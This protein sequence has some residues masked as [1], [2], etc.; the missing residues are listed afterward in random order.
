M[1]KSLTA[2]AVRVIAVLGVLAMASGVLGAATISCSDPSVATLGGLINMPNSNYS[3]CLSQDKIYSGFVTGVNGGSAIPSNWTSSITVATIGTTDIHTITF[4][5]PN[6]SSGLGAGT[7]TLDFQIAIDPASVNYAINWITSVQVSANFSDISGSPH[8]TDS[9]LL[10]NSAGG[11]IGTLTSVNGV[12]ASMGVDEKII[13]IQETITVDGTGLMHSFTDTFIET[14][15]P[16]PA[17]MA[18]MGAGLLGLGALLRRKRF[19]K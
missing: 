7:Y 14:E 1:T 16:E 2:V 6:G 10:L 13:D 11:T 3:G 4:N 19:A 8:N 12:T 18:L 5:A 15:T 17:T 9:K